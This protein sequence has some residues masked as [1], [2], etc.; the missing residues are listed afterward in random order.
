[1]T[2]LS[3]EEVLKIAKEYGV[4]GNDGTMFQNDLERFAAAMYEAGAKSERAEWGYCPECGCSQWEL[5]GHDNGRFC[6][7]CGQEWF[8]H[9]DYTGVVRK[10]LS[11]FTAE[12]AVSERLLEALKM[13]S[14]NGPA[15]DMDGS[16][17]IADEAIAEVEAMRKEQPE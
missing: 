1:M 5:T 10:H 6:S 12:R 7:D 4:L 13:I 17:I 8:P 11:D 3:R 14:D 16:Y 15:D 2:E 9:I